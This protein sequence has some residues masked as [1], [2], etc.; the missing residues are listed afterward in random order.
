VGHRKR[1]T[2]ICLGAV[3][4]STAGS[5]LASPYE[6]ATA[7]LTQPTLKIISVKNR[8]GPVHDYRTNYFIV[9]F[10][11][12]NLTSGNYY[13]LQGKWPHE[14]DGD[15]GLYQWTAHSTTASRPKAHLSPPYGSDWIPRTTVKIKFTLYNFGPA[16]ARSSTPVASR[17]VTAVAKGC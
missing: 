7:P 8:C 11:A 15:D 16:N 2:A 6:A 13:D 10:N 14:V 1:F 5:A 9:N 17:S 12:A 4:A 3:L